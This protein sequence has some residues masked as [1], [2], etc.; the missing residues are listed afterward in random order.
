MV[1]HL[2]TRPSSR[3]DGGPLWD[4]PPSGTS[5]RRPSVAVRAWEIRSPEG[6]V[7]VIVKNIH[8][9]QPEEHLTHDRPHGFWMYRLLFMAFFLCAILYMSLFFPSPRSSMD[10]VLGDQWSKSVTS[11]FQLLGLAP[12]FEKK[13]GIAMVWSLKCVNIQHSSRCW[14]EYQKLHAFPPKNLSGPW[15]CGH[16]LRPWPPWRRWPKLWRWSWWKGWPA[17]LPRWE[18]SWQLGGGV[19]SRKEVHFPATST[20]LPVDMISTF[21]TFLDI[22]AGIHC[23]LSEISVCWSFFFAQMLWH[24]NRY[25]ICEHEG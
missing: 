3:T 24:H 2:A 9:E 12:G 20:G 17:C 6:L 10:M 8:L 1:R 4:L 14:L 22:D 21:L 23:D 13:S 11:S 18:A 5:I 7:G 25:S 16:S 19:S 15:L